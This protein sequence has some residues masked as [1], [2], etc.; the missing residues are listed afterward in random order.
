MTPE[1]SCF[2]LKGDKSKHP[3]DAETSDFGL[4]MQYSNPANIAGKYW[5]HK[6]SN[7]WGVITV[8]GRASDV[9]SKQ[10]YLL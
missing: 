4:G 3:I 7:N 2:Q 5:Y 10:R 1:W 6:R 9:G 8:G